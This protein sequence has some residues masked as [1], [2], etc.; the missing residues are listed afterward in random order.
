[1][2]EERPEKLSQL[3]FDRH[4]IISLINFKW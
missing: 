4:I 2:N 1:M 3:F